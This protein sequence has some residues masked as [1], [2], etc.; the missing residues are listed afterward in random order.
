MVWG[1]VRATTRPP[2]G[3]GRGGGGQLVRRTVGVAAGD[4]QHV[5]V[6]RAAG[7][8]PTSGPTGPPPRG[9]KPLRQPGTIISTVVPGVVGHHRGQSLELVPG[10]PTATAR[11]GHR[12]R[13]GCGA[14]RGG[15]AHGP[16]GE[17]LVQRAPPSPASCASAAA[18]PDRLVAHH[19]PAQRR[20]ADQEAGVDP[21][22]AVEAGQPLAE[23]PPRP[24]E[25]GL[26]GG[27]RH[28]LDPGHHPGQVLG[29]LGSGRGQG[30]P[31]VAAEHR[32]DPVQRRR[33]GASGPRTAGRR[34]G[35]GGRRTQGPPRS[36]SASMTRAGA[37]RSTVPDGHDPA[38]VDPDV[39]PA[40][41]SPGAVHHRSR[42][43]T[44]G[45]IMARPVPRSSPGRLTP[46]CHRCPPVPLQSRRA[47]ATLLSLPV[48]STLLPDPE[49][50]VRS[51]SR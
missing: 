49:P 27:Q 28:A 34:S 51:W 10:W 25:P 38:V 40:A 23:R 33:A 29:V 37:T 48:G 19:D 16:L 2:A 17:G 46:P 41:R 8:A 31:A 24:V 21:D 45:S 12:R 42:P 26:E 4:G 30:E 1:R 7:P 5:P 35:C 18:A 22:A 11:A 6:H 20:V 39:G 14:L 50:R 15:E 47:R 9:L 36:P 32:G 13:C 3:R 43:R 44:T